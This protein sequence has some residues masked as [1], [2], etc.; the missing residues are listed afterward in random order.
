MA[1]KA[2]GRM[3][4]EKEGNHHTSVLERKGGMGNGS[5]CTGN[6]V[7]KIFKRRFGQLSSVFV[8]MR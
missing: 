5:L 1:K 6:V 3:A 7:G 4:E 8:E 2:V